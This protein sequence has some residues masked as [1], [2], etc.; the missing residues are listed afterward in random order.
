[1]KW[2]FIASIGFSVGKR[3]SGVNIF[4]IGEKFPNFLGSGEEFEEIQF[5]SC[6]RE[7]AW[8]MENYLE[9]NFSEYKEE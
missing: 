2:L 3:L 6:F 5:C 1:M 9:G 4:Y 8:R 7:L